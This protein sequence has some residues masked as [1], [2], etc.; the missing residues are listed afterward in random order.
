MK[1]ER[2]HQDDQIATLVMIKV[3]HI[4]HFIAALTLVMIKFYT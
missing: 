2:E 3:L 4:N 1:C